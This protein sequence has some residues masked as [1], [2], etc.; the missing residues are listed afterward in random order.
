M[1]AVE[2]EQ[3]RGQNRRGDTWGWEGGGWPDGKRLLGNHGLLLWLAC[4]GPLP[5][6]SGPF[7]NA[8]LVVPLSC[9]GSLRC[10][11]AAGDQAL[12]EE[13]SREAGK[14]SSGGALLGHAAAGE[15]TLVTMSTLTEDG[16][17]AVKQVACDR[18]LC[19]RVEVKLKVCGWGS[20]G[21]GVGTGGGARQAG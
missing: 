18:L 7:P 5:L 10:A 8:S 1:G 20:G 6:A 13:M 17:A 2:G 11:A 12:V 14:I 21:G 3:G 16:I 15:T 19:S 9:P 4:L